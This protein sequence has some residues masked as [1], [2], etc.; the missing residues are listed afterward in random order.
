MFD[1]YCNICREQGA[2]VPAT[3]EFC[4]QRQDTEAAEAAQYVRC[5]D[6]HRAHGETVAALVQHNMAP[7]VLSSRTLRVSAAQGTSA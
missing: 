1:A 6:Q 5:C 4:V 2:L 3:I 7:A